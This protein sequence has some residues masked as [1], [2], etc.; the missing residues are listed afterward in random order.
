MPAAEL[1][2]E[3]ASDPAYHMDDVGGPP[4]VPPPVPAGLSNRVGQL[5]EALESEG[6]I[7]EAALLYEV[8]AVLSSYDK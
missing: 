8:Q 3:F 7:G 2:A 1:A 6:R 4:P 5:A